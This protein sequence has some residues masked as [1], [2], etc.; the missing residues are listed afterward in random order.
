MNAYCLSLLCDP[1]HSV[2]KDSIDHRVVWIIKEGLVTKRDINHTFQ[3]NMVT[4]LKH[5]L[6]KIDGV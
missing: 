6:P 3:H 5:I 2:Q 1:Y 4:V